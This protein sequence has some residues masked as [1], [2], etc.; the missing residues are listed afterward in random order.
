MSPC[1]CATQLWWLRP[2]IARL[3]RR[4]CLAQ[5]CNRPSA[6]DDT[7][8]KRGGEKRKKDNADIRREFHVRPAFAVIP[9][10]M[11]ARLYRIRRT[12]VGWCCAL[13]SRSLLH[14]SVITWDRE[15]QPTRRM[16]LHAARAFASPPAFIESAQRRLSTFYRAVLS[17]INRLYLAL[18]RPL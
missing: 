18:L 10:L 4:A 7:F 1:A 15:T 3:L 11:T 13:K 16:H 5:N 6:A 9:N 14:K 17:A 12:R 2:A 8:E